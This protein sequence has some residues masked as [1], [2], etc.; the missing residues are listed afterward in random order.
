MLISIC[1]VR[2]VRKSL[3]QKAATYFGVNFFLQFIQVAYEWISFQFP[4]LSIGLAQ[5]PSLVFFSLF[6]FIYFLFMNENK[7]INTLQA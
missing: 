2:K 5:T 4:N 3:Q 7:S 1:I 6:T